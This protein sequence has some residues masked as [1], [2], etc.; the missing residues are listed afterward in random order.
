MKHER[1]SQGWSSWRKWAKK[2]E[3][4]VTST[5]KKRIVSDA[6]QDIT[7]L[8]FDTRLW[9]QTFKKKIVLCTIRPR[10][11]IQKVNRIKSDFM[12]TWNGKAGPVKKQASCRHDEQLFKCK[13]YCIIFIFGKQETKALKR[14]KTLLSS[15]QYKCMPIKI[16]FL[17]QDCYLLDQGGIKIFVW[18]GKK[19]SK[20]ERAESLKKAEVS[21]DHL[22][23][24]MKH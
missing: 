21:P 19:A 5:E 2:K 6:E 12:L 20:T 13:L 1:W 7:L 4:L 23:T 9:R 22:H 10:T 11:C 24:P 3:E 8:F 15:M 17:W 18:K 14:K 16:C